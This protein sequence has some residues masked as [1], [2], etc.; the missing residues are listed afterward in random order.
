MNGIDIGDSRI[1]LTILLKVYQIQKSGL[2]NVDSVFIE[3]YLNSVKWRRE[4]PETLHEAVNDILS[5][6]GDSIVRYLSTRAIIDSK[7][8][9]LADFSSL[10]E[11]E[12][13]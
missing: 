2:D 9:S 7:N 4:K 12:L 5:I 3:D 11:G 1:Q 8:K 6:S 13:E 10:L